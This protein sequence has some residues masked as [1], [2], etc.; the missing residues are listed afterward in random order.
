MILRYIIF[1][2]K[3]MEVNKEIEQ[4]LLDFHESKKPISFTSL[5]S[6]LAAKLFKGCSITLGDDSLKGKIE[7]SG[8]NLIMAGPEEVVVDKH[9]RIISSPGFNIQTAKPYQIHK[10]MEELVSTTLNLIGG[11]SIDVDGKKS[12]PLVE[13]LLQA[14]PENE[15]DK[16]REKMSQTK[17]TSKYSREGAVDYVEGEEKKH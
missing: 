13:S 15:R 4:I 2:S 11:S 7:K 1:N 8:A 5:G 12:N 16:L 14:F 3:D 10:G 17:S 9:N 6:V